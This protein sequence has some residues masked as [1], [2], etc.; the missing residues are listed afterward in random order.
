M[1]RLITLTFIAAGLNARNEGYGGL[2]IDDAPSASAWFEIRDYHAR[3]GRF[4]SSF[5]IA[6][7]FR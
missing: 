2:A 5:R 6:L 1:S 7:S 4:M 3:D